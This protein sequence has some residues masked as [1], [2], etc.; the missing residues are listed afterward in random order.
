MPNNNKLFSN[1]N[2]NP[3]YFISTQKQPVNFMI[4]CQ[5]IIYNDKIYKENKK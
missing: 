4:I 5:Y 2:T 3:H 1:T